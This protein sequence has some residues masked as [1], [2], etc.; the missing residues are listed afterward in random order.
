[1]CQ[2]GVAGSS[3]LTFKCSS[4][5]SKRDCRIWVDTDDK[6]PC[7]DD[8]SGVTRGEQTT[9]RGRRTCQEGTHE[10]QKKERS[11][12]SRNNNSTQQ[13]QLRQNL[14]YLSWEGELWY[15]VF[16]TWMITWTDYN[17]CLQG[18]IFSSFNKSIKFALAH[19]PISSVFRFSFWMSLQEETWTCCN[20]IPKLHVTLNYQSALGQDIELL[21]VPGG[22]DLTSELPVERKWKV[23]EIHCIWQSD[24]MQVNTRAA[25]NLILGRVNM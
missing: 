1:M 9:H 22:V 21:P 20:Q 19:N 4:A 10:R 17:L 11:R 5:L 16:K 2:V 23:T 12:A 6:P 7:E 14:D 3:G 8:C 24:L 13:L 18:K 15:L 25:W